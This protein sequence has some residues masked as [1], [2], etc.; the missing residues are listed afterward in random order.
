MKK[1]IAALLS[2]ALALGALCG[3]AACGNSGTNDTPK[4]AAATPEQVE[5]AIADALGS[6]YLCNTDIT[7]NW[8]GIHYQI[9]MNSVSSYVA[10]ENSINSVNPDTVI[11]MQ[12]KDAESAQNLVTIFNKELDQLVSY[13][14]QY[15]YDGLAKVSNARIYNVDNMVMFIVAGAS[16]D[17]STTDANQLAKDE[18]AKIDSTIENLL[19][20]VP[21]NL[22]SVNA[23]AVTPSDNDGEPVLS[24]SSSAAQPADTAAGDTSSTK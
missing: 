1:I 20:S 14:Q 6:D 5:K 8:L 17:N 3:L 16:P 21:E 23:S 2:G 15:S 7:E 9:D 19:G 12:A 24:E 22:A 4:T 13:E 11:I 10:K 18:Y